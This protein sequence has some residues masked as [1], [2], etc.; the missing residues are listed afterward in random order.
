MH[1][2]NKVEKANK[3]KVVKMAIVPFVLPVGIQAR[4]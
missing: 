3:T 4:P 2:L 1:G